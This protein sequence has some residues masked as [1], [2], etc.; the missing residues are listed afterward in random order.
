M[1]ASR[2]CLGKTRVFFLSLSPRLGVESK[3]MALCYLTPAE[4]E[5]FAGMSRYDRAHSLLIAK[6]LA[7]DRDLIKTALLHDTGKLRR[8]LPLWF[9]TGYTA[10]EVLAPGRLQ[11][12]QRR[13][14][15]VAGEGASRESLSRLRGRRKRALFVQTHHGELAA[16]MLQ[17]LGCE[18]EV[19][20]LVRYHQEVPGPDDEVLMRF[21]R[22]D[23]A[24]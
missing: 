12:A 22:A 8:E 6:A 15:D 18:L 21:I 17:E 3:R 23:S 24:F 7:A 4:T 19:V 9:R 16:E 10:A 2:S 1:Q 14:A 20:R 11:G 13:L 5:L